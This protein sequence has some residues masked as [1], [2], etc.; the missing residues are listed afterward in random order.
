MKDL[1][2]KPVSRDD[3]RRM[4]RERTGFRLDE[5][6][7]EDALLVIDAY[8]LSLAASLAEGGPVV[9]SWQQALSGLARLLLDRDRAEESD[10]AIVRAIREMDARMSYMSGL[11]EET[12]QSVAAQLKAL[13]GILLAM[14][15]P[16][17]IDLRVPDDVPGDNP[18]TL[19][20]PEAFDRLVRELEEPALPARTGKG[21]KG[22]PGCFFNEDG[23]ITCRSCDE[24][25]DPEEYARD[26]RAQTGR[27]S[28]C[29]KCEKIRTAA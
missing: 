18:A 13:S 26:R 23:T 11:T 2:D 12:L 6:Q 20:S 5:R 19:V 27:K 28:N 15:N 16:R 21:V 9:S 24:A 10:D 29:K 3:V 1:S 8:A 22:S 25:K 14:D 7:T 17:V 4:L